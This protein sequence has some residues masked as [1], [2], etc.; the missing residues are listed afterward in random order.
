MAAG[1]QDLAE[2]EEDLEDGEEEEEEDTTTAPVKVTV[3][4]HAERITDTPFFFFYKS[5]H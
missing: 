4:G 1:G 3:R 2:A 5:C